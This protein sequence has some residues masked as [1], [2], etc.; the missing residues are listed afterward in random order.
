MN[1]KDKRT[2]KGNAMDGFVRRKTHSTR[3]RP[4][5]DSSARRQRTPRHGHIDGFVP[6]QT[7]STKPM[8]FSDDRPGQKKSAKDVWTDENT[9][10]VSESMP[11]EYETRQ[12]AGRKSKLSDGTP[13]WWQFAEKRRLKKVSRLQ[14]NDKKY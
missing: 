13:K 3:N 10:D 8:H 1:R 14:Q 2:P 9:L 11:V 4:S 5:L 12:S 7:Q 6:R